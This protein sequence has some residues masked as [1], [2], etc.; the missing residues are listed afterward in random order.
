MGDADFPAVVRDFSFQFPDSVHWGQIESALNSLGI[1]EMRSLKPL[2]IFRDKKLAAGTESQYSMLLQ[3]VFQA[4]DRTLK[5]EELQGCAQRIFAAL[6]R[7][8]GQ[9]RFPVD[10]L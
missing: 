10:L 9:P 6:V 7:L 3:A 1:A 5:L 8:G 2:E 4:Q